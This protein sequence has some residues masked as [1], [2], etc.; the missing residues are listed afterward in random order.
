[1]AVEAATKAKVSLSV[2]GEM[3]GDPEA[4]LALIGLGIRSLSMS[5]ASLP[6][7]R[8]A[9]RTAD[10]GQLAGEAQAACYDRSAAAARARFARLSGASSQA[11]IPS[12]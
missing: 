12:A 2:C 6:A 7:V 5:A 1:M 3:A 11:A 10:A 4:A 8:R 9:I